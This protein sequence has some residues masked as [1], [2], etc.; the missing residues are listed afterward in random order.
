MFLMLC[1]KMSELDLIFEKKVT[2]NITSVYVYAYICMCIKFQENN[3]SS[4]ILPVKQMAE[5]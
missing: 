2:Q 4:S 1:Q 5:Y 3:K